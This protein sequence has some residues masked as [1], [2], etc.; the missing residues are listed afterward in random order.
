MDE[1]ISRATATSMPE[2]QVSQYVEMLKAQDQ[3][4]RAD[5]LRRTGVGHGVA[6]PS[7][8]AAGS[9]KV[10]T[11]AGGPPPPSNNNQ[12]G[13]PGQ[14]QGGSGGAGASGGGGGG[15]GMDVADALAARLASLRK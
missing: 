11:A 6:A 10:A 2:D 7:T 3:L 1:S 8:A 13:G 14:N 5:E 9:D 4:A 15:G 12:Q